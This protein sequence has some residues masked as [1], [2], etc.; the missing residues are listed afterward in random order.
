MLTGIRHITRYL[1]PR[2]LF[3]R[4]S[5]ILLFGLCVAHILSFGMIV[6]ERDQASKATMS[7]Y[8][9]HDVAGSIAMLER[10]PAEERA[11]WLPRLDRNN[12]RYFLRAGEPA[13]AHVAEKSAD[14]TL[15]IEV[16]QSVRAALGSGYTVIPGFY[17]DAQARK[18]MNLHLNLYDG[19]PVSID[20][21]SSGLTYSSWLPLILVAQL[22]ILIAFS[23]LA[24]RLATRPLAQL[25]AAADRVSPDRSTDLFPTDGPLEVAKAG[26][27]FNA[28]QQRISTYLSERIQI[29]AAVTHDLQTPIT[30]MRL[31]VEMSDEEG[32]K[33]KLLRDLLAMQS[34]VE[35]GVAYARAHQLGQQPKEKTYSLDLDALLRSLVNDYQDAGH[36]IA[37]TAQLGRPLRSAPHALKRILSNLLDNALKFGSEVEIVVQN[38]AADHIA[39]AVLDRGPGIPAAELAAVLQ[40][41]YRVENSRNRDT[42]GSGLGLAIAQQLSLA[43]GGSLHLSNREGGGLLAEL[44]LPG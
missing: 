26:I 30:R 23:W 22:L 41:Y 34:L 35:Q 15:A 4:I 25:A 43:L 3:G 38:L 7:Y 18:H 5:L 31:R 44:R 8:L 28:M 17:L 33:D 24:V 16:M 19:T 37:L 42:G 11:V 27:A 10:L 36:S 2:S 9:G 6:Y 40:P 21:V 39:I 32:H 29:L 20:M 14:T 13:S 12:Y 1:W